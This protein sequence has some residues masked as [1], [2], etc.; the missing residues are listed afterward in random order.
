MLKAILLLLI[1]LQT[2]FSEEAGAVYKL[3]QYQSGTKYIRL[4][5]P[6]SAEQWTCFDQQNYEKFIGLAGDAALKDSALAVTQDQ[7]NLC[8]E[9]KNLLEEGLITKMKTDALFK[10]HSDSLF[11]KYDKCYNEL[12]S[13][14]WQKYIW[15]GGGLLIGTAIGVVIHLFLAR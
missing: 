3:G 13:A 10:N 15:G 9:N 4:K 5:I 6:E 8:Q 1:L 11:V 2:P 7:L 12:N 14:R